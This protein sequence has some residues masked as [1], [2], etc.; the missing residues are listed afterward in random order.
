MSKLFKQF[1]FV[2]IFVFTIGFLFESNIFDVLAQNKTTLNQ[3]Q[4]VEIAEKFVAVNGYTET[5]VSRNAKLYFEEGEN[6]SNLKNILAARL[7]S[8]GSRA[9]IEFVKELEGQSFWSVQFLFRKEKIEG[10]FLL[11]R[12]VRM[13]LEGSKVWLNPKAIPVWEDKVLICIDD[14]DGEKPQKP[15]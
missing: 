1:S 10:G 12:E 4:A 7:G 15:L 11:G 6:V 13:S 8:I 5:P 2:A 3:K 14:G 9:V